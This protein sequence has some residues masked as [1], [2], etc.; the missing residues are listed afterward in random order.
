MIDH[1]Q[2]LG[3]GKVQ[4][5]I[6]DIKSINK[7]INRKTADYESTFNQAKIFKDQCSKTDSITFQR[8]MDEL[9]HKWT[10][11]VEKCL[12][13]LQR[14]ERTSNLMSRYNELIKELKNWLNKCEVKMDHLKGYPDTVTRLIKEHDSFQAELKSRLESFSYVKEIGEEYIALSSLEEAKVIKKDMSNVDSQLHQV[15]LL[16]EAKEK[17][18]KESLAMAEEFQSE[19]K[20]LVNWLNQIETQVKSIDTSSQDEAI[21]KRCNAEIDTLSNQMSREKVKKENIISLGE[22][23]LRDC[24]SDAE[25][26]IR[27]WIRL[28]ISKWDEIL[29]ALK[30]HENKIKQLI[31]NSAQRADNL[32]HLLDWVRKIERELTVENSKPI[33]TNLKQLT[34]LI[35]HLEEIKHQLRRNELEV[36]QIAYEYGRK[37]EPWSGRIKIFPSSALNISLDTILDPTASELIQRWKNCWRSLETRLRK[38][39][40]QFNY[41]KDVERTRMFNFEEWRQQ[42]YHPTIY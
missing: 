32:K 18:L 41:L 19:T 20:R 17:K 27:H 21:I 33:P 8:L 30:E 1:L 2:D 7:E 11:T 25:Y 31:E 42:S 15:S 24:H 39:Q 29:S 10:L 40:E 22:T 3:S 36:V 23:L 5:Y 16:S 28:I 9:E 13:Q 34:M 26:P 38:L 35:S 14:L 6:E 37:L 4:K 12:K